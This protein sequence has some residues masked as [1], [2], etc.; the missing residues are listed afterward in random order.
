MFNSFGLASAKVSVSRRVTIT[1]NVTLP[2]ELAWHQSTQ[3]QAWQPAVQPQQSH[4]LILDT[5]LREPNVDLEFSCPA[6][7]Y[8]MPTYWCVAGGTPQR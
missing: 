8:P 3:L 2:R 1:I 7:I 5:D 4:G 6:T